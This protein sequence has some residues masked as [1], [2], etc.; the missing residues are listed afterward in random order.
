MASTVRT[1]SATIIDALYVNQLCREKSNRVSLERPKRLGSFSYY[2]DNNGSDYCPDISALRYLALPNPANINCLQGYDHNVSYDH[3]N[4]RVMLLLRW[5]LDNETTMQQFPSDFICYNGVIKDMMT[6]KHNNHDWNL[7]AIKIR[8]KIILNSKE[9]IEAKDRIGIEAEKDNKLSYVALSL[10]RLITK[11]NNCP[12]CISGKE[13]DYFYGVFHSNIGSHRILHVG[14]LDCAESKQELNKHF[15]DMKFVSIEKFD[16][17]KESQSSYQSSTWWSMAT[18]AGVDT[19][20]RAKCGRDFT[21]QNVDKLEVKDLICKQRQMIFVT[22]L[23]VV[24][25]FIKSIVTEKYKCYTFH[26]NGKDK[27]LVGYMKESEKSFIPFW[28]INGQPSRTS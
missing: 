18:L 19:I 14:Q 2:D 9:T 17:P 27:Q 26:F 16:A 8:G 28:Y 21:I 10:Q 25:N 13:N 11:N 24:L 1:K 5:V 3:S 12:K 6:V 15:D 7:T 20:I 22:S 4:S 23:N